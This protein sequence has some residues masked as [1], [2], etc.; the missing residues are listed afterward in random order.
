MNYT[1]EQLKEGQSKADYSARHFKTYEAFRERCLENL[2]N[3]LPHCPDQM[4]RG[5][6]KARTGGLV[7]GW[8]SKMEQEGLLVRVAGPTGKLNYIAKADQ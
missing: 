4:L 7:K 2:A 3:G 8:I 1:T 5:N 6:D